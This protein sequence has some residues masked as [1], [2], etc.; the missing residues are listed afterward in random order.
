MT[1]DFLRFEE[2]ETKGVTQL[3]K[4]IGVHTDEPLGTITETDDGQIKWRNGWRR[5]IMHFDRDCDW[6]VE[7]LAQCYK[8]I[9][10]LM[11]ERKK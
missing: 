2:L 4:V 9:Q 6:S 8:F 1:T 5:Y 11:Q 7:C 3:F 10:Q